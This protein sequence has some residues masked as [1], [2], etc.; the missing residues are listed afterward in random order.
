MPE[1][2]E[3]SAGDDLIVRPARQED[4]DAVLGFTA[5]TWS[6]GGD[7]IAE[8]W[9]AWLTGGDGVLLVG[10]LAGRPVAIAHLR[11]L[12]DDEGWIEGVRVD[13]ALRGQGI[14]SVM[15]S[16][17]LI[18]ARE[19]GASVARLFTDSDNLPSQAL[20]ARFGFVRVAELV[21]YAADSLAPGARDEPTRLSTP[22]PERLDEI[23]AW[24]V[25]SNLAPINGGLE[26]YAWTAR[27][28]TEPHL[29][30]YL[31]AG[32]VSL[33]EA[34]GGIQ[35]LAVVAEE[36]LASLG[37]SASRAFVVRYLDGLADGIGRLAFA[38]RWRAAEFGYVG[39]RLWLP[40]LLI[41]HDAMDG[42]GYVRQDDGVLY[43]Y[44]RAL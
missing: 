33:L 41:L 5:R 20:F 6:D 36:P 3:H 4:R 9:D 38:L 22:G 26:I 15:L 2:P 44:A 35:A 10:D 19:R 14:G 30:A 21:R 11:M 34:W 16:R 28:V 8:V 7:Y 12:S 13:P 18:A 24:L 31:A 17:T 39:V 40:D 27:A 23:W 42:A 1:P 43:A 37:R 32:E 29:L 25:Q